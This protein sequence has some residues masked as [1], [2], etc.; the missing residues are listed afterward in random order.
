MNFTAESVLYCKSTKIHHNTH[1]RDKDRTLARVLKKARQKRKRVAAADEAS[2][3]SGEISTS[4]TRQGVEGAGAL[5]PD[6]HLVQG[7]EQVGKP[8]LEY[9]EK[10]AYWRAQ[11]GKIRQ[12]TEE[13]SAARAQ[14]EQAEDIEVKNMK[15]AFL[16][17]EAMSVSGVEDANP[18]QPVQQRDESSQ[19]LQ[20]FLEQEIRKKE[21]N[22]ECPVC[23]EVTL[24]F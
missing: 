9:E 10:R 2:N 20:Q 17:A 23:L 15:E 18:Y 13:S 4:S 6:E 14:K 7:K 16:L 11:A 21:A 12:L 19:M 22:L 24:I 3:A 8:S 1:F 5:D